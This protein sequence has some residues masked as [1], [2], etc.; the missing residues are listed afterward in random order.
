MR[1]EG[2]ARG[3]SEQEGS[4]ESPRLGVLAPLNL[5]VILVCT[6]N[7][8]LFLKECYFFFYPNSLF[9]MHEITLTGLVILSVSLVSFLKKRIK[10]F[11]L[12]SLLWLRCVAVPRTNDKSP[13]L[14][15]STSLLPNPDD[16]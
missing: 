10:R 13:C 11:S 14:G 1:M 12:T 8:C 3:E 2:K 16:P 7:I 5:T 9:P 4:D 15:H 6:A